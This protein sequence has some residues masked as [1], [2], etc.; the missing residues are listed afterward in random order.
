MSSYKSV[1]KE[2]REFIQTTIEYSSE[3]QFVLVDKKER[4][5]NAQRY[6]YRGSIDDW[7]N[8]DFSKPLDEL[9]ELYVEHLGK[10]SFFELY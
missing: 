3:M 2:D 7:M 9:V 5:F 4:L 8:I 10:E 1:S 6:N